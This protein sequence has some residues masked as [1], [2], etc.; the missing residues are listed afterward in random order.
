MYERLLVPVDG[1]A[2][3]MLGLREAIRL[4]SRHGG[5]L[6]LVHVVDELPAV[7]PPAGASDIVLAQLR[8]AGEEVLASAASEAANSGVTAECCLIEEFGGQA[9]AAIIEEA[10]KWGAELIVCGTHGRRGLGRFVMGSDA[11]YIVRRSPVPVLL[12]PVH[13]QQPAA[14]RAA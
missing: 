12:V 4:A 5:R 13:L 11:E 3:A 9:G 7:I 2:P 8:G 6:H 10:T 1:S 14:A